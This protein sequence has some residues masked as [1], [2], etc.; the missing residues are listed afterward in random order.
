MLEQLCYHSSLIPAF[1]LLCI[2]IYE[3]ADA[4]HSGRGSGISLRR[5][6]STFC[7]EAEKVVCDDAEVGFTRC[8][9]MPRLL[10]GGYGRGRFDATHRVARA[11]QKHGFVGFFCFAS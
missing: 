5:G 2:Y 4:I 1:S 9:R 6:G 3:S 10:T 8:V 11:S 7:D